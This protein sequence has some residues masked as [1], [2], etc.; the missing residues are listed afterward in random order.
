MKQIVYKSQSLYNDPT[1]LD[2]LFDISN[3][4]LHF[5]R[6]IDFNKILNLGLVKLKIS[7]I[8]SSFTSIMC[9]RSFEI[10]INYRRQFKYLQ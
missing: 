8:L 1:R 6:N 2:L 7:A 4:L 9:V 10:I 5:H 3:N